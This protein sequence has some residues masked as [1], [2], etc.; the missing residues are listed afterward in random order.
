MVAANANDE[1][2]EVLDYTGADTLIGLHDD[3]EAALADLRKA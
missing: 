3:N 2:K 1:V